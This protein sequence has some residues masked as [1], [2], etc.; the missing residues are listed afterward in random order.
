MSFGKPDIF[1]ADQGSQ[2][3][4]ID[5][6]K[7]LLDTNIQLVWTAKTEHLRS[8][9]LSQSTATGQ[10]GFPFVPFVMRPD[11][12]NKYLFLTSQGFTV[13]KLTRKP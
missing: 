8:F 12:S 10:S 13:E 11:G 7:V 1:N 3:T 5:F 6:T 9:S 2:F 4:S